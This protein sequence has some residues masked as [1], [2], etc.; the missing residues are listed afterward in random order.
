MIIFILLLL[1]LN[2]HCQAE[3]KK[4]EKQEFSFLL[5]SLNLQGSI[6]IYDPQLDNFY[7]NDFS[8]A[9]TKF[10]PAS[11]FKIPNS[12]VGLEIGVLNDSTIF[13]WDG[14]PRRMKIWEQDLNLAKAFQYSCV[15]CY[16]ENARNI[17]YNR[18][19]EYL[20]KLNYPGMN[21]DETTLDN[22][23]LEG[24]SKIS[25]FEQIDFISRFYYNKLPISSSTKETMVKLL[26]QDTINNTNFYGKTGWAVRLK[27][28]IGWFVGFQEVEDR[29]YFV[30][31]NV[32]P[33][34]SP[35]TDNFLKSRVIAAKMAIT[36]IVD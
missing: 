19:K 21:F 3:S 32:K 26:K 35:D 23:W 30:V 1:V 16:Q 18:M 14:K 15:P 17:G 9:D 28:N 4:I 24:E 10:I 12:I 33:K 34:D 2:S 27:E 7:S 6:L 5:D 11:T 20:K 31:V 8:W 29:V 13:E 36:L 25:S 22:F